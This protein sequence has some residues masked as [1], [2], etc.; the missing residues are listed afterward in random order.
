MNEA[1]ANWEHLLISFVLAE[2]FCKLLGEFS[3]RRV[4]TLSCCLNTVWHKK[5]H[6]LDDIM[7][8]MRTLGPTESDGHSRCET[9]KQEKAGRRYSRFSLA[10]GF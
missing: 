4:E 2:V 5:K 6:L 10:K 9:E 3:T 7:G 8:E 1:E